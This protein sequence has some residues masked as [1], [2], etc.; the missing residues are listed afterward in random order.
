MLANPAYGSRES[1]AFGHDWRRPRAERRQMKRDALEAW[2]PQMRASVWLQ[3]RWV[4]GVAIDRLG[5][6]NFLG[7]LKL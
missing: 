1:V 7:F 2:Q 4:G 5:V 6:K 3:L